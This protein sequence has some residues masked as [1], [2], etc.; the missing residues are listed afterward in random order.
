VTGLGTSLALVGAYVLA[1]E[2]ARS[3]GAYNVAFAR[4]ESVMRDYVKQCQA[5]PPGGLEGMLPRTRRAIWMRNLSTRMM[6]RWP[7]RNLVA[8]LFQKA[9]A[10]VLQD[11]A[12]SAS[13]DLAMAATL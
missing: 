13:A 10:I 4:Y 11:Y 2:L 9:D 12:T 5:L 7:M 3:S 1:G 6:T 8:R